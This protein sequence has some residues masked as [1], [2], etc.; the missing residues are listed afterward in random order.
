[1]TLLFKIFG[2]FLIIFTTS[3]LGFLKSNQLNLRFKKLQDIQKGICTLKE[4]IRMGGGEIERLLRLSFTEYPIN[5]THLE[6]GDI[7]ILEEFFKTAGMSDTKAEYERCELYINLLKSKSEEA[8]KN[9][10]ETGRLY[11]NIG[12]LSGIFICIFL[13]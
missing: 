4:R 7:E 9:Y 12:F 2:F 8:N 13:L 11:R 1:M 3:A 6:K 10:R 5:Y